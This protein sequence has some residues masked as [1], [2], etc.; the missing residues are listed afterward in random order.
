MD[1]RCILVPYDSGQREVRMGKGP[2]KLLEGL[3]ALPELG[4]LAVERIDMAATFPT[5]IAGTF[6]L[7][8]LLAERVR[9][10]VASGRFPLV[11]TGNC[12]SAVGVLAGL[13]PARTSVLW[14]DCHGDFNTSD[15]T[16]S[17]FL[18]SMGLA[19]ALEKRKGVRN[20]FH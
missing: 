3:G 14:F 1:V 4:T 8:R 20:R 15:T 2:E 12:F 11:L 19:T 17:G 7:A 18:D 10:A 9:H 5:E 16:Q 6:T 13:S